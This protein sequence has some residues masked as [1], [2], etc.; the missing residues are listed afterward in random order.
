M[1]ATNF[2]CVPAGSSFTWSAILSP[3]VR[4]PLPSLPVLAEGLGLRLDLW[5][6]LWILVQWRRGAGGGIQ[7]AFYGR[8][9]QHKWITFRG[10]EADE[11][12]NQLF[13]LRV[14]GNFNKAATKLEVCLC[15]M[16][17]IRSLLCFTYRK[18][19]NNSTLFGLP[20]LQNYFPIH[21]NPRDIK[22][23]LLMGYKLRIQ[24]TSYKVNHNTTNF[25]LKQKV[26]ENQTNIKI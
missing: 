15:R 1:W 20:W 3:T 18:C 23:Y 19:N 6:C 17:K 14:R 10:L 16:S 24:P 26:F 25:Y 12:S 4:L 7:E 13:L 21:S 5:W 2:S 9:V 22:K 11:I 8:V